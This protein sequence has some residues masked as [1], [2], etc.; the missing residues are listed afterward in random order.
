MKLMSPS[1]GM[2]VIIIAFAVVV[3]S[4]LLHSR[5]SEQLDPLVTQ[6][7]DAFAEDASLTPKSETRLEAFGAQDPSARYAERLRDATALTMSLSLYVLNERIT[8]NHLVPTAN[9]ALDGLSK[10]PLM[11]PGLSVASSFGVVKSSMGLYYVRYRSTPFGVEVMAVGPQGLLDGPVFVVR[12]SGSQATQN[13]ATGEQGQ[14]A[15]LFVS[16]NSDAPVPTPFAPSV[17]YLKAGWTQEPLRSTP[18]TPQ[19]L[20]DLQVW[21][22]ATVK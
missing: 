1:P 21:L 18:L 4:T 12:V 13:T 3:T 22:A 8:N 19:Q 7:T 2:L 17:E 15:A 5:N 9:V 10:S 20:A 16:P 14:G 6:E 11:P